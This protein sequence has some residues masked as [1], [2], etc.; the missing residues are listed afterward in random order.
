M[1]MRKTNAKGGEWK[2]PQ[3][4]TIKQVNIKAGLTLIRK[5]VKNC[6]KDESNY[7]FLLSDHNLRL[8]SLLF[9]ETIWEGKRCDDLQPRLQ[10]APYCCSVAFQVSTDI[11]LMNKNPTF[12][13]TWC[14]SENFLCQPIPNWVSGREVNMLFLDLSG[15]EEKK[16]F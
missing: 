12:I 11:H 4:G 3:S 1:K 7:L 15:W 8:P 13:I 6:P 14:L 10:M 9:Q 16:W 2:R 5:K